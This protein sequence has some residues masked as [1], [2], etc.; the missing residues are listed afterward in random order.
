MA[1]PVHVAG[2]LCI[3]SRLCW[4]TC[5]P[6]SQPMLALGRHPRLT[7]H[8]AI[9]RVKCSSATSSRASLERVGG[10]L[11]GILSGYLLLA[12][13]LVHK[14][15]RRSGAAPCC[16]LPRPAASETRRAAL[17]ERW[18]A[19]IDQAQD[20]PPSHKPAAA[21][22]APVGIAGMMSDPMAKAREAVASRQQGK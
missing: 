13:S 3:L 14:R 21:T 18:K 17:K 16:S 20:Q 6:P 9:E 10:S 11:G 2:H 22:A 1:P 4:Q 19:S 7:S 15:Y 8:R 5:A 12:C